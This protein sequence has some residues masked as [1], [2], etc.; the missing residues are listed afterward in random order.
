[1][2]SI[3][4]VLLLSWDRRDGMQMEDMLVLSSV[5]SCDVIWVSHCVVCDKSS[6]V[7]SYLAFWTHTSHND[8]KMLLCP[9][10]TTLVSQLN[11]YCNNFFKKSSRVQVI[12]LNCSTTVNKM[13][14]L[15]WEQQSF[16]GVFYTQCCKIC[17]YNWFFFSFLDA[18][19]EFKFKLYSEQVW[20]CNSKS[21]IRL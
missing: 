10:F 17:R 4:N 19:K 7:W 12:A 5:P 13:Y 14:E 16:V 9:T 2:F 20:I 1:M 11:N 15:Q 21:P 18:D 6:S 8:F 3:S